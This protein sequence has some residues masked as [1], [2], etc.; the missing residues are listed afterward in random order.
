LQVFDVYGR[1]VDTRSVTHQTTLK[2][3]QDYKHGAYYARVIQGR[4]R[5][6]IKLIKL[7][8]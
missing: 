7:N 3:G 6:E 1:V 4:K 2:I 5:K 8:N